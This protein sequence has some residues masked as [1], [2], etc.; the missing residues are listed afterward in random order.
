MCIDAKRGFAF[1]HRGR[2]WF[3]GKACPTL[4]LKA[5]KGFARNSPP[6]SSANKT[7]AFS[8]LAMLSAKSK[9]AFASDAVCT[10]S[11]MDIS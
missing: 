11:L 6:K 3:T 2:I 1:S 9:T 7:V 8:F 4:L 10:L 5:N